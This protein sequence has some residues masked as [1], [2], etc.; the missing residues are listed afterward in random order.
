MPGDALE[1]SNRPPPQRF[2]SYGA[3]ITQTAGY[4]EAKADHLHG[5][6][7]YGLSPSVGAM[8]KT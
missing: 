8:A 4:I 3:K 2:G 1:S 5:A 6:Y 7:L